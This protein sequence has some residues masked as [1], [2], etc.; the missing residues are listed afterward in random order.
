MAVDLVPLAP[1]EAIRALF[2]RGK[3]LDPSF[4]WQDVWQETH[5]EMF[6]VAKSAGFDILDDIYQALLKALSEGTT[7]S[8]FGRELTP[9]LQAKGW[10]GRQLVSDPETGDRVVAQLGS[11]RRLHTIFDA[12]MRVS[13]ATG[14]WASF[15]RN[16]PARPFLRYVCVLD[17]ATRRST[18]P[19]TIWCCRS[20]IRTGISGRRRTGGIAAALCKTFHSATWT[21]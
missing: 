17:D 3:Q 21:G 12:N 5:T 20:I 1:R 16:K 14:H 11:V 15:E 9:L 13:Y 10:W 7:F 8:T 4:A 2:E 19:I 18:V 6:T